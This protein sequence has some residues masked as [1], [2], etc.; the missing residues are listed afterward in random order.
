MAGA[1]VVFAKEPAPGRV[2]TRLCPPFRP[3]EAASFYEAMLADVLEASAAM[4][5]DH[6]LSLWVAVDPAEAAARLAPPGSQPL[7]Q[8]GSDLSARMA[9]AAARAFG[10]G[11]A[12]VLL[13][14]SDSPTLG[15]DTLQGA[16]A[17]LAEA[18]VVLCPDRDGGYNLVGLA[19]LAPGVFDHPMSTGTVLEDTLA[20]AARRGLRS[21]VLPAG[22]DIDVASDL[23][24]LAEARASGGASRCPRTLAWLDHH[25]LWP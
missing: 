17:G 1:L 21:R 13:R 24:C 6:G 3:E 7:G 15:D 10:A 19:S 4:A 14:G 9:H 11:H 5:R 8:Q 12:P 23:T 20:Q 18:D 22:F 2:K 25:S 16:L